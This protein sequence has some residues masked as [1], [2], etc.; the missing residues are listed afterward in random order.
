M[1]AK[2]KYKFLND[3]QPIVKF[4]YKG[5]HDHPVQRTGII[6]EDKPEILVVYELR[7]GSTV[8][9]FNSSVIKSYRKDKIANYEHTKR[10]RRAKRNKNKEGT[11]LRRLS[12]FDLFREG[13]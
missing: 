13:V 11:T 2:M 4:Y 1:G 5:H 6:I 12:F 10:L 7:E 8:R 3:D 9:S